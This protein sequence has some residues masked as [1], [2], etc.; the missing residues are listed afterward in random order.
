[1][2]TKLAEDVY[3][4]DSCTKVLKTEKGMKRHVDEEHV[5]PSIKEEMAEKLEEIRT[6]SASIH[7][8]ATRL[9]TMWK[10]YGIS[11]TFDTYPNRFSYSISNS[12]NSPKGYEQNWSRQS[13]KPKGYPGWSGEWKGKVEI[14]DKK[15]WKGD[16]CFSDL[17]DPWERGSSRYCAPV[18]WIKIASGSGGR[19][20]RYEGMFFLYDFPLMH[21]EFKQKGEEYKVLEK[22]YNEAVRDYKQRY[23]Q[24]RN[25]HIK[26]SELY[27]EAVALKNEAVLAEKNARKTVE[28]VEAHLAGEFSKQY[29]KDVPMPTSMFVEDT[30]VQKAVTVTNR[31]TAA[32]PN[33]EGTQDYL[34]RL[35]RKISV[36]MKD[37]PEVFI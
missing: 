4:C 9:T 2:F 5:G 27:R 29:T 20:F 13:D 32:P 26:M 34:D 16:I 18:R 21:K 22:E 7:E 33:L 10:S 31:S 8:V 19:E 37:N 35:A 12:H 23:E 36:Y 1:M 6:T 28:Q 24:E 11:V 3:K 14:I 30:L 17:I 15:R 25:N